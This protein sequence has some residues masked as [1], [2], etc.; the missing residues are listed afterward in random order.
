MR[1]VSEDWSQATAIRV[2]SVDDKKAGEQQCE[3]NEKD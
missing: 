1:E 2:K 3:H